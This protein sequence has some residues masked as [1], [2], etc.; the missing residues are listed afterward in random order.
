MSLPALRNAAVGALALVTVT[1]GLAGPASAEPSD[2][3]GVERPASRL[4]P[5]TAA[6]GGRTAVGLRDLRTSFRTA[7]V[8]ARADQVKVIGDRTTRGRER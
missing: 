8:T 3:T 4:E 2:G 6:T 7:A 1:G 5:V